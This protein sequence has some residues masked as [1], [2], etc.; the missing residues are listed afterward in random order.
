M[1][2]WKRQLTFWSVTSVAAANAMFLLSAVG[3]RLGDSPWTRSILGLTVTMWMIMVMGL[4]D[5][6]LRRGGKKR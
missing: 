3:P 1:E 2:Y 5:D 4:T 6:M